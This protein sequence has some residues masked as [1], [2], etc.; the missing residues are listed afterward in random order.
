MYSYT[1]LDRFG[2]CSS[3]DPF[4]LNMGLIGIYKFNIKTPSYIYKNN[5]SLQIQLFCS[6]F[7]SL[8]DFDTYDLSMD[9]KLVE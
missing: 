9:Y 7:I 4:S 5:K 2:L 6:H 8:E 3:D 1:Y